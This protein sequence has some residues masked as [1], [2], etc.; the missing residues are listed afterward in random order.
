MLEGLTEVRHPVG[1]VVK[2]GSVTGKKTCYWA[3]VGSRF[4]EFNG[5]D[6]GNVDILL[7]QFFDVGTS[8]PRDGFEDRRGLLDGRHSDADVV[9]RKTVHRAVP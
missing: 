5:S 8:G 7:W 6:E 2:A 1:D 4:D 3:G 9:E